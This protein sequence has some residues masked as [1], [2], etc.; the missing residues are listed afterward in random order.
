MLA[1]QKNGSSNTSSKEFSQGLGSSCSYS[2]HLSQ[3]Q[4]GTPGRS[5]QLWVSKCKKKAHSIWRASPF[6]ADQLTLMKTRELLQGKRPP[7]AIYEGP[8]RQFCQRKANFSYS[9]KAFQATL[10][11]C[12]S[13]GSFGQF[14]SSSSA[15]IPFVAGSILLI[16]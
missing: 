1:R 2:S 5:A 9:T 16:R 13:S 10:P 4:D 6:P 14:S 3:V 7:T 12:P 11:R 15:F 8:L